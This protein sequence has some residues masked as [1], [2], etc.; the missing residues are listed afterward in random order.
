MTA[1]PGR[2][3]CRARVQAIASSGLAGEELRSEALEALRAGLGATFACW[4]AADPG[5]LLPAYHH[6][7]TSELPFARC[8]PRLVALE[9]A[10][11]PGADPATARLTGATSLSIVTGGDLARERAWDECMRPF[12]LGDHAVAPCRDRHGVWGWIKAIRESG[13]PPYAEADLELLD[14]VAASI[15]AMMRRSARGSPAERP[16]QLPAPGVLILDDELRRT[17]WTREAEAWLA[18]LPEADRWSGH[19]HLP[20]A[21]YGVAGRVLFGGEGGSP[22]V[23]VRAGGGWA[24]LDGSLLAGERADQVAITIRA[25]TAA[26]ALD[27]LCRAYGLTRR[28]AELIRLLVGGLSTQQ[29]AERL[30]ITP[31]TVKDHL[32]SIFER[33][34]VGSRGELVGVITGGL[35]DPGEA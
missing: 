30:Y 35:P 23:R 7:D 2:A 4:Q 25:A 14:A 18:L 20:T 29:I 1:D 15:A 26:E 31:Y 11:D 12:G 27:L 5:S 16:A 21:V 9:Q 3:R 8:V 34:G 28:E 24:V 33:V 22:H 6:T 32:K 19:G 17:S 13:D 10:P